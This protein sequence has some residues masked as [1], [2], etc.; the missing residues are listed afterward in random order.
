VPS[1]ADSW[2]RC[3]DE[4]ESSAF[5]LEMQQTYT[6]PNEQANFRRFLSGEPKPE[7]HNAAWHEKIRRLTDAGKLV[8]R[9]KIIRWPLT[10]YLRYQRAWGIPG[11]VAAGEDYRMVDITA[12]EHGLPAQ[13]FWLFDDETVVHLN[14]YQDGTFAGAELVAEPQLAKYRGWRDNA[15]SHGVPFA[16]WNAGSGPA[17]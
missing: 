13:D 7:D 9:A 12:D 5:R 10:D 15:L 1:S 4:F 16:E 17:E 2:R 6:M 11:N 8:Q 3:F 14:Y